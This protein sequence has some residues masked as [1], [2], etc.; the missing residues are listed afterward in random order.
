[1]NLA[2]SIHSITMT[3]LELVAI[4]NSQRGEDRSAKFSADLPDGYGRPRKGYK[5]PKREACLM[6]MSYSYD[7]QAKVF[8]HMKACVDLAEAA[9]ARLMLVGGYLTEGEAA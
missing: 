2:P 6:A 7:I 5:F 4:I 1:M 3:S 8:D 9:L